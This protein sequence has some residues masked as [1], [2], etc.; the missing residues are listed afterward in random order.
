MNRGE[1]R[2]I[3]QAFVFLDKCIYGV[4]AYVCTYLKFSLLAAYQGIYN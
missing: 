3:M 1:E 2:G 4:S